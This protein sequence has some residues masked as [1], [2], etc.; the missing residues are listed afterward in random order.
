MIN[1]R[2]LLVINIR[3]MMLL[4]GDITKDY[5]GDFLYYAQSIVHENFRNVI[6]IFC[7]NRVRTCYT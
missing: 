4:Q 1:G 6:V 3:S 2:F 5:G 7:A